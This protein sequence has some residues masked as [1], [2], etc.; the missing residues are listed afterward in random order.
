MA[1]T[2]YTNL[3]THASQI[4]FTRAQLSHGAIPV[5]DM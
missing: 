4:E 1:Y 2:E 5:Q 3:F